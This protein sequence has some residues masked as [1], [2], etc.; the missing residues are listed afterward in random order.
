MEHQGSPDRR[1]I[2]ATCGDALAQWN[3]D[4]HWYGRDGYECPSAPNPEEGPQPG[5]QPG[6]IAERPNYG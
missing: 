4:D 6:E 1:S 3:G 2:C 5:H